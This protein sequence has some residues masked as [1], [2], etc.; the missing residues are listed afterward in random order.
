MDWTFVWLCFIKRN[1]L[2]KVVYILLIVLPTM[3]FKW[4]SSCSYYNWTCL[5]LPSRNI[6][7]CPINHNAFLKMFN[8]LMYFTFDRACYSFLFDAFSDI[9]NA[10]VT[11]FCYLMI[12][13]QDNTY[14]YCL[15]WLNKLMPR[16]LKDGF[17]YT[18][19]TT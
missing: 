13:G 1:E 15:Q 14:Y 12:S 11:N 2:G 5:A 4:Q 3:N 6:Y 17:L 8:S 10:L 16:P 9:S 18:E 19:G 7:L